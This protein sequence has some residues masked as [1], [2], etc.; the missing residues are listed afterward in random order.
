MDAV[1]EVREHV[2]KNLVAVSDSAPRAE[3]KIL[4]HRRRSE[5]VGVH[6]DEVHLGAELCGLEG[7]GQA[8]ERIETDGVVQGDRGVGAV[9]RGH[10]GSVGAGVVGCWRAVWEGRVMV[11]VVGLGW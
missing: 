3:F 6:G 11:M 5:Y 1:V 9:F 2:I 8:R 7:R 10:G 4:G